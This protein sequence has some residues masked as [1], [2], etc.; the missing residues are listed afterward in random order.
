VPPHAEPSHVGVPPSS[1]TWQTVQDGPQ[2]LVELLLTQALL[3]LFCPAGHWHMLLTQLEP[4]V[5]QPASQAPQLLLSFVRFT[6][7]F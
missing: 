2:A 3:Q 7:A 5:V 1:G 6:H 4:S